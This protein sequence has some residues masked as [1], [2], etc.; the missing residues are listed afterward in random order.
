MNI[1]ASLTTS[2]NLYRRTDWTQNFI[3]YLPDGTT[4]KDLTNYSASFS[5]LRNQKGASPDVIY[6]ADCSILA[7]SG[8]ITA[9]FPSSQTST[10]L[11]QSYYCELMLTNPSGATDVWLTGA[12]NII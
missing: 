1:P 10:M 8:Q 12:F 2:L 4:V 11:P 3:V 9:S 7:P 6:S 5:L